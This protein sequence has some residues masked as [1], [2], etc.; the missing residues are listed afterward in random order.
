MN[1]RLSRWLLALYPRAWRDRYGPEVSSLTDE[2]IDA[3]ETTPMRAGFDLTFSAVSERGRAL[4]RP[5]K[6]L[7]TAMALGLMLI[8]G[9][10]LTGHQQAGGS[11][12]TWTAVGAGCAVTFKGHGR[13]EN[14]VTF[15]GH[16]KPQNAVTF[17]GHGKPQNFVGRVV[18]GQSWT[19][20]AGKR[21]HAF[22]V[23]IARPKCGMP[24]LACKSVSLVAPPA[25]K[26]APGSLRATFSKQRAAPPPKRWTVNTRVKAPT[27]VPSCVIAGT[28]IQVN[29]PTPANQSK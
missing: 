17:K 10:A 18:K 20:V 25:P 22:T 15:K 2:L 29:K 13:P 23:V 11:Q 27:A 9:F 12:T 3:G 28:G 4:S 24:R 21:A 6:V 5:R 14:A 16:G 19:N 26:L 7:A 8:L 1:R